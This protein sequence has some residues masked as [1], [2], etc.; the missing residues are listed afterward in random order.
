MCKCIQITSRSSI[1]P[2]DLW[3]CPHFVGIALLGSSETKLPSHIYNLNNGNL[4]K[5]PNILK[6]SP[7]IVHILNTIN[8]QGK[9][10][11]Y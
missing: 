4:P 9:Y 6:R 11:Q 2:T 5:F 1:W 10:K 8:V 3:I 7:N